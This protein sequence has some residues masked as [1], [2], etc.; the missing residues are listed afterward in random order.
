MTKPIKYEG[1]AFEAK[2]GWDKVSVKQK[3]LEGKRGPHMVSQL[4]VL[5][6]HWIGQN[7]CLGFSV[8]GYGKTWT[9]FLANPVEGC[10]LTKPGT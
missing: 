6:V 3:G 2:S 1:K 10:Q 5:P 7:V 4:E 8:R 9:N